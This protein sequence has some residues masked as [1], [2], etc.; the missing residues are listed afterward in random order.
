MEKYN[1]IDK[2]VLIK[3]AVEHII[4]TLNYKDKISLANFVFFE[5]D[6]NKINQD[7]NFYNIVK[8]I[9]EKYIIETDIY[10]GFVVSNYTNKSKVKY[11]LFT[12]VNNSF[13][14]DPKSIRDGLGKELFDRFIINDKSNFHSLYGFLQILKMKVLF[15]NKKNY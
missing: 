8:S 12:I 7:G 14:S 5:T 11:K 3:Y 6:E 9:L 15:L 10:K 1:F 13:I 2:N 4:D